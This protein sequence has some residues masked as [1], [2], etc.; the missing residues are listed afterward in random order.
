MRRLAVLAVAIAFAAATPALAARP[1]GGGDSD[2]D[3]VADA[4]DDCPDTPAG[5]L[6]DVSGC[7]V[8]PCDATVD[9]DDWGSHRSYLRC[10]TAE[11]RRRLKAHVAS[12]HDMRNV[13]KL[14]RRSTCGNANVTRC[15]VYAD[16]DATVGTCRLMS[17]D[18]CDNLGDTAVTDDVGPGSC[19]PNPCTD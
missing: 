12:K 8:C 16:D 9:G 17:P 5:D 18:D 15:C 14:A 13:V 4:L 10:V 2:G 7:S 1:G 19:V 11:T 6:V 3:G